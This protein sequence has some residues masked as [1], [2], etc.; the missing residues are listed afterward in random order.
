MKWDYCIKD[1]RLYEGYAEEFFLKDMGKEGWELVTV[2]TVRCRFFFK[3][4]LE[5]LKT[6]EEQWK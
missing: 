2:D 3:R 1:L 4:P 5:V 6:S